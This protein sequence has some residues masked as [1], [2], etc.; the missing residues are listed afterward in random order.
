MY[1]NTGLTTW[2]EQQRRVKKKRISSMQVY[3]QIKYSQAALGD[4]HI[5]LIGVLSY[6]NCNFF[7]HISIELSLRAKH[8][9]LSLIAMPPE[10]L[11]VRKYGDLFAFRNSQQ[12]AAGLSLRI[13]EWRRRYQINTR[14]VTYQLGST[15]PKVINLYQSAKGIEISTLHVLLWFIQLKS[16]GI[17]Y[18]V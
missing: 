17:W 3:W 2:Y 4:A 8:V 13:V 11:Q 1:L 14:W 16:S 15:L 9:Q 7:L 6:F 12:S 10:N 5:R 18:V